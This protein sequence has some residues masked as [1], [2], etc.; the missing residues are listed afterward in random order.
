MARLRLKHAAIEAV[1]TVRYLR[2]S[3]KIF[4]AGMVGGTCIVCE[5]RWAASFTE[6]LIVYRSSMVAAVRNSVIVYELFL[7]SCMRMA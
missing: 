3:H 2:Y 5:E 6:R 7:V 1:R 4:L